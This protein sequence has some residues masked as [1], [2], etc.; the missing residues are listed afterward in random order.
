[1]TN[2]DSEQMY[3]VG[4]PN[5][6]SPSPIKR[7]LGSWPPALL[8]VGKKLTSNRQEVDGEATAHAERI[9]RTQTTPLLLLS[10]PTFSASEHKLVGAFLLGRNLANERG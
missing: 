10:I 4:L 9:G 5:D 3:C 7:R 1:M 6:V 8:P 2:P